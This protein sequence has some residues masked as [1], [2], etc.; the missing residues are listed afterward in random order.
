MT[1]GHRVYFVVDGSVVVVTY[2]QLA[3]LCQFSEESGRE[4]A[5]EKSE[6]DG[7]NVVLQNGDK[8][9]F[10]NRPVTTLK[11]INGALQPNKKR[12]KE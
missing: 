1:Q 7:G 5:C 2:Q 11:N 8:C 10:G 12:V 4:D 3:D 6:G 9:I